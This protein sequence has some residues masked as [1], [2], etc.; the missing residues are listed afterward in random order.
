M[1][2]R[3]KDR[4]SFDLR[5]Y[6]Y[7]LTYLG[8]IESNQM[9]MVLCKEKLNLLMKGQDLALDSIYEKFDINFDLLSMMKQREQDEESK[10]HIRWGEQ[11]VS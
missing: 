6:I 1:E 5:S 7:F 2:Y 8:S 11:L 3:E 10:F 4:R 9:Q